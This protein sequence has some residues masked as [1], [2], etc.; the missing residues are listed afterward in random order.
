MLKACGP[1]EW[2]F[3]TSLEDVKVLHGELYNK[4]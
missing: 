1:V 3:G 2:C 4:H